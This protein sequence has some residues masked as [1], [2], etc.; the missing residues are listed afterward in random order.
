ML[1]FRPKNAVTAEQY[2]S[3]GNT[4]D[5]DIHI[6]EC[7]DDAISSEWTQHILDK[8]AD[9]VVAYYIAPML[10]D[11]GFSIELQF[12]RTPAGRTTARE[13]RKE[14][15][16]GF[17]KGGYVPT[18]KQA[19]SKSEAHKKVRLLMNRMYRLPSGQY[20]WYYGKWDGHGNLI[21]KVE[22]IDR[23]RQNDG[24]PLENK[25]VRR[26]EL[27]QATLIPKGDEPWSMGR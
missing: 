14:Y 6:I 15:L 4:F 18:R 20:F 23:P 8:Y 16:G 10:G 2:E 9:E 13:C 3:Q 21:G 24:I 25:I 26:T 17:R 22:S 5:S 7:P 11:L 27:E 19:I 12:A 1:T